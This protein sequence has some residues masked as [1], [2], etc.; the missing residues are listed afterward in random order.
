M[1]EPEVDQRCPHC[2][3][4]IFRAD[5]VDEHA[6]G[7]AASDP[8]L[9]REGAECFADCPACGQ[10]VRMAPAGAETG[11]HFVVAHIQR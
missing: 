3:A 2:N 1:E 8:R 10:P 11:T 7:V 6:F 5:R 9:Y 4:A